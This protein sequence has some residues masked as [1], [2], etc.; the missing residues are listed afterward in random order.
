MF[1]FKKG[2]PGYGLV[3]GICFV[4]L[5]V[6]LLTIGVLAPI[7]EEVT[8]R[9]ILFTGFKRT[10]RI[11]GSILWTAFLFG[12]FHMNLNQFGYAMMIGIVSAFLVE[13]TGSLI[14]SLILHILIAFVMLAMPR[15]L[16]NA[17]G[18][19][20]DHIDA[21]DT[22]LLEQESSNEQYVNKQACLV[23]VNL[24]LWILSFNTYIFMCHKALFFF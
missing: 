16:G 18:D 6:L 8:F 14:P 2:T 11:F 9:G 21:S 23:P 12:L 1:Q 20:V 3:I 5:G 17:M 15:H 13:A 19:V 24:Y 7:C 10:N 22:L 4:I